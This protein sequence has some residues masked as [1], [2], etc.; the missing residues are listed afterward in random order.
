MRLGP[1][2]ARAAALLA[3]ML[4]CAASASGAP[5]AGGPVGTFA[6]VHGAVSVQPSG[7]AK[8]PVAL[9]AP[10]D[11]GDTVETGPGA[12]A[13][14]ALADHERIYL[15]PGTL[16]RLDDYHFSADHPA[17]SH[18]AT[19]LLQG[20]LRVISGL[21]GHQGNPDAFALKTQRATIGIRGTEWWV[22]DDPVPAAGG[23]SDAGAAAGDDSTSHES[24][25]VARG[26][27]HV[28]TPTWQQDI[29]A[30]SGTILSGRPGA[31][32]LLPASEIPAVTPSAAAAAACE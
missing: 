22:R 10:V 13:V 14:L 7:G 24:I 31:F 3:G 6:Y 15:K 27:I 4:V 25:G 17:D 21:I 18:S 11:D 8:H 9:G 32:E 30:G 26:E 16:Y 5:G 19:T 1:A 29:P 20:G 28:S 23:A 2:C 12:E